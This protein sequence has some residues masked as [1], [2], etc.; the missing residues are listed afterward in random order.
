[1]ASHQCFLKNVENPHR[2]YLNLDFPK[3]TSG[4]NL[5]NLARRR[6]RSAVFA[7]SSKTIMFT[8][9]KSCERG[10]KHCITSSSAGA[11]RVLDD[12]TK[13]DNIL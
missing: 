5:S 7:E 13:S 10:E 3:Y 6:R 8:T 1:M 12:A 9:A 2:K 4:S 11:A